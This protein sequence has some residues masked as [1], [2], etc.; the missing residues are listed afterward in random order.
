[1]ART[2]AILL[3]VTL[4]VAGLAGVAAGAD[5]PPEIALLIEQHRFAP[6]EIRVKAGLPFV[7]VITNRDGG[8][9]EFESR[10]LRI[11]KIIPAGKTIRLRMPALKPGTYPFAGEYHE[12]TAQGRIVA[13]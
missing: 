13:E 3:A 9:E 8:A 11:E 10:A 7:L 12:A 2:T 4:A 5:P 1:M 6:A